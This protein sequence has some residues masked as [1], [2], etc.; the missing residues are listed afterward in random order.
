ME[1][2]V[3]KNRLQ[4]VHCSYIEFCLKCDRAPH[5]WN[6]PLYPSI[7]EGFPRRVCLCGGGGGRGGGGGGAGG[8]GGQIFAIKREGW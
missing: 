1:L 6:L 3:T 5:S 8:R 7:K 4:T 2:F